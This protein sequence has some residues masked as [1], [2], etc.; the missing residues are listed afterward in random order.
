MEIKGI[1]LPGETLSCFF[2]FFSAGAYYS[3]LTS[4]MPAIKVQAGIGDADVGLALLCLGIASVTGLIFCGRMIRRF[5]SRRLLTVSSAALFLLLPFAGLAPGRLSL[6][7]V[8]AGLGLSVAIFDVCMNTQAIDLE[9]Q[10]RGRYTGKMQAGYSLGCI[11]G[12]ILGSVFAGIG[13]GA[14]A[15]FLFFSALCLVL[16]FF[17]RRHLLEDFKR[18]GKTGRTKMPLFIYFCGVMEICAFAG[19]GVLGDW[20]SIFLHSAKGAPE[21]VAALSFGVTAL[22]MAI[23][24]MFC[25]GLR[26]R[27]GDFPL[28]AGGALLVAAGLLLAIFAESPALCLGGFFLAGVGVAPAV[29]IVMSRAGAT[30]SVDPG[31]A[32]SAVSAVGYGSLLFLPPLLGSV[33][34]TWGIERAFFIPIAFALLL[35]AGSFRFREK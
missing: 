2:F 35:F 31:A 29:P 34:Q 25:D 4:R 33:A 11:F 21:S 6:F 18:S 32:C 14:F 8:F 3:L 28:L 16:W 27:V 12:A 17:A 9:V 22:A 5:S 26:G 10:R 19:E 7:A 24:R 20:G 15:N 23:V 13:A 1:E 30:P